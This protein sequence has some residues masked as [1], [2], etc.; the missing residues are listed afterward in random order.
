MAYF[1]GP[2]LNNT[3]IEKGRLRHTG[4]GDEQN[5]T[6]RV[7]QCIYIFLH[8]RTVRIRSHEHEDECTYVV[9]SNVFTEDR[10]AG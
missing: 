7:D 5:R 3:R 10:L 9:E 4:F 1:I 6:Q 2:M 8:L